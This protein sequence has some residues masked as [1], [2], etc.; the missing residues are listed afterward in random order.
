M[1]QHTLPSTDKAAEFLKQA[2]GLLSKNDKRYNFFL[3]EYYIYVERNDK[4]ALSHYCLE[5]NTRQL[6]LLC[7]GGICNS[8]Q[9]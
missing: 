7:H 1:T 3:G 4:K 6:S 8:Q 5:G 9:L 2:V